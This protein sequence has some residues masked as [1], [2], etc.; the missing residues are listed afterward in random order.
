MTGNQSLKQNPGMKIFLFA[1]I[2][3]TT[4]KE[5]KDITF[6]TASRRGC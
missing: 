5:K 4:A 6:D 3:R 2:H 1:K